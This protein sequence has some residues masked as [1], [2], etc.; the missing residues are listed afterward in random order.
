V[1]VGFWQAQC[2]AVANRAAVVL[3][4]D[5][6]QEYLHTLQTLGRV[7]LS[8][9]V[10]AL[11]AVELQFERVGSEISRYRESRYGDK[12]S[13]RFLC[14]DPHKS[15]IDS[16]RAFPGGQRFS[17]DNSPSATAGSAFG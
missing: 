11:E 8:L 6:L 9:R 3:R 1:L 5:T 12:G 2:E 13:G 7:Q 10:A 16:P 14:P 15:L 4:L 17:D